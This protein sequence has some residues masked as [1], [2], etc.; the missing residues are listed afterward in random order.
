[1]SEKVNTIMQ[2]LSDMLVG[3]A[4]A[5]RPV[6]IH[7][8][9]FV[10]R[11]WIRLIA[12]G[13]IT[14]AGYSVYAHPPIE[15]VARGEVGVRINRFSG[16]TTQVQEGAVIVIPGLHQMRRFP[17]RDQFY[18]PAQGG[19]A[20]EEGAFQSMEGLSLGVD[21]TIRYALD[22][23][24]LV[25]ISKNLPDDIGGE[26]VQPIV[27]GV[28]YKTFTRY[29]V[30]DIFSTKRGE[31]QQ[32]IEDELKPRLAAD[33]I[34][35]RTVLVGKVDLPEEFSRGMET[36]LAEELATEKMRYTLDL[37]EKQVKQTA[38]EA[39]SE[40]VKREKAAEAAGNEQIIAAKA[41][42]EAMQHVLPFKEKQIQQRQLE[43]EAEKVSRVKTAEGMADARRIEAGGEA[44]S[45]R[46][47][48]DADAYR[49]DQIGK[50]AS[51]QL[52]RDGALL[53]KNPLLIQK[54]MAD[55][56]SDKI[57]VII[58]PPPA[59][60]GFIG[61]ALLGAGQQKRVA[62]APVDAQANEE[63]GKQ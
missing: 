23:S 33:G 59:D 30:R 26:V 47:L 5:S 62:A 56:L 37:K 57:S 4:S 51:S 2:R 19:K 40:K 11:T 27:R 22:Q 15:N 7:T 41:Q 42:A 53:S 55:K 48:A 34:I 44:D 54:T 3:A 63:E 39:D 29:S 1:M 12:L 25:S 28:V 52:E 46:K 16:D 43:A 9:S 10:K 45:R 21:L 36:L 14:Y 18:R 31:I 49:M 8:A 13:A 32:S 50:I 61:S 17:T 20:S 6:F 38:L 24:K 35:L 58:A 60:G